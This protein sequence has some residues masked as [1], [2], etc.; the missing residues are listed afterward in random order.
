MKSAGTI[1]LVLF[2]LSSLSRAKT[3]LVGENEL[4]KNPSEALSHS[5][6]GDVIKISKGVY[7]VSELVIDKSITLEGE[8]GAVFDGN[9]FKEII[10]V[11]S[12]SVTVKNLTLRNT[13]TS[14]VT[15]VAAIRLE[16]VSGCRLENN[17]VQNSFFALYLSSSK[18][19]VVLSN[20]IEGNAV[21]ESFSGN[22]IHLWKCNNIT[23]SNNEVSG[24]RDGIYLEFSTNSEIT[25]NTS[26]GNLRYGLHFMFSEGNRYINNVFRN[27]GAGVAVMYTKRIT[28]T[29]NRFEDNWGANSY[30]LL[31][32]DIDNSL[33]YG[34]TFSRNTAA[35]Y[36][37]GTNRVNILNN[38]F[39]N[40]GWALK[41][42]G[43][44]YEDS[45]LYNNFLNNTFD[46]ATN[47]PRNPNVFINNYWDKYKGYDLDNDR[48]GDVPYRPVSLFSLVVEKVPEAVVLTG[49]FLVDLLDAA[50]K[51]IPVF[52]PETLADNY[53]L[54][55]RSGN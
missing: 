4:Y 37:E 3:I 28:M 25:G 49:S 40:N 1:L 19:C 31:L 9:F 29:G 15:D 55:N 12:D 2:L 21:S 30:G 26:R 45:V 20:R 38:I 11:T 35:I 43:N 33:I 48:K 54:M 34:N 36:M 39:E 42:L 10:T 24:Q 16:N 47:S 17:T 51:V 6:S 18:N 53:P 8:E 22:G 50:E 23:I 52:T 46:V 32:K 7:N 13:G 5:V 44:C 41:I 27:N 14:F